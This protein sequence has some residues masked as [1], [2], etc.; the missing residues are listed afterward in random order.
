MR[1]KS[2]TKFPPHGFQI[3]LPEI[4]MKAP[5]AGSFNEVVDAFARIVAKNPAIAEKQGWPTHRSDQENWIDEREA[6]RMVAHGWLNFVDLEGE[7]PPTRVGGVRRST[8]GAVAA[9][10]S[11]LAIYRELFSGNS[12]PVEHAEAERRAAVC[13]EC[14]LNKQGGLKEWF[15]EHVAK[16][17]TELYGIMSD[18]DLTTSMDKELGTCVA[19]SCPTRAKVHVD[20]AIIKR[21]TKPEVLAKLDPK[22]W[23]LQT[24]VGS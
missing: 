16:G 18:L 10:V 11:G 21:N 2:R 20:L 1:L 15:V 22:C 3:L 4:G 5:T 12:K 13:V 8:P 19:C 14:P 23:I 7:S 6:K 24:S 9:A 17:I